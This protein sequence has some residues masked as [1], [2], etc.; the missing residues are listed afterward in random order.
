MTTN[1]VSP[2][3]PERPHALPVL[4]PEAPS[5]CQD[6]VGVVSHT[7]DC[8][9]L[10]I[11][12]PPPKRRLV[13]LADVARHPILVLTPLLSPTN[14]D[15]LILISDLIVHKEMLRVDV[16]ATPRGPQAAAH[17]RTML[18]GGRCDLM[19]VRIITDQLRSGYMR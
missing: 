14:C 16:K 1:G 4:Y 8:K 19:L 12:V 10:S 5:M 6:N 11:W 9:L 13:P 17:L 3:R 15:L 7:M 2:D 18:L